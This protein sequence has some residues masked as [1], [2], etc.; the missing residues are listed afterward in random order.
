MKLAINYGLDK[1]EHNYLTILLLAMQLSA[2]KSI[3]VCYEIVL[4]DFVIG[5]IGIL[6]LSAISV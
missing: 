2:Q 6:C 5:K 3:A 1:I 4:V